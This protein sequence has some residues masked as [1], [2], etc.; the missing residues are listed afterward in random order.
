MVD[1][2]DSLIETRRR[3]LAV[4]IARL[5][6]VPGLCQSPIPGLRFSRRDAS[7]VPTPLFYSP[8][9]T[10]VAQGKK[11]VRL[12]KRTYV[13]DQSHYL[14]TAFDLPVL[15]T[16]IG[17]T[18][19]RPFLCLS[20]ELD[21]KL[22]GELLA[23]APK[24]APPPPDCGMAVSRIDVPLIDAALRLTALLSA[25]R[26]IPALAPLIIRE[27]HYRLLTGP[28]G[29]RLYHLATSG[30]RW[31]AIAKLIAWMKRHYTEPMRIDTLARTVGMSV[32][33]LHHHFKAIAAVSPLQYQKQLRLQEARRLMLVGLDAADA[34][35]RVGYESPSQ[36]SRDYR[37]LFGAPPMRDVGLIR[38]DPAREAVAE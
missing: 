23:D 25:P 32:S 20:L 30:C 28:Q 3:E 36:F 13:Y 33:S 24:G 21:L 29:G 1:Q 34:G 22:I 18:S 2:N 4:R 5:A 37:R 11:Q 26:D 31:Q 6:K 35:Y 15:S 12:A 27:I 8:A 16:V 9:L 7:S 14:L 17:A 10:L 19:A 38:R